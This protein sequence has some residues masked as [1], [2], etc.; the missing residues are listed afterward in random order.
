ML[1]AAAHIV[2]AT[3][4]ALAAIDRAYWPSSGGGDRADGVG[5]QYR[6]IAWLFVATGAALIAAKETYER[7][8]IANL[9]QV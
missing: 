7:V 5:R 1:D 9:P 6:A 2:K 4:C 3:S 8:E